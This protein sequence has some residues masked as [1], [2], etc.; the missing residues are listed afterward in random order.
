MA[1][2]GKEEPCRKWAKV[3][4]IAM[5]MLRYFPRPHYRTGSRPVCGR[6]SPL[7][8]IDVHYPEIGLSC[9]ENWAE[10]RI[11][12]GRIGILVYIEQEGRA[13]VSLVFGCL[14]SQW[15]EKGCLTVAGQ[16][17]SDIYCFFCSSGMKRGGGGGAE[18][19]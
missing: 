3:T 16:E 17:R 7:M 18:L 15:V 8:L 6:S 12:E 10:L 14:G 19:F 11:D 9:L 5:S 13:P 1:I 2:D 4:T